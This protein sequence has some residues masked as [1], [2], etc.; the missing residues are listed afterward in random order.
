VTEGTSHR[1]TEAIEG[2]GVQPLREA[3]L[4]SGA[5][6]WSGTMAGR[7]VYGRQERVRLDAS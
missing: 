6:D 1:L 5:T 7:S 4:E 3:T 2:R